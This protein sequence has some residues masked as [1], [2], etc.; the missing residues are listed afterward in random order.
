MAR[1]TYTKQ[2]WKNLPS[3]ETPVSAER[4]DYI[5]Q[6]IK[7]AMDNRALKEIYGDSSISMGRKAGTSIRTYSYAVGFNVTASAD[8]S[9]AEGYSTIAS[10]NYS[11]AEG[12][13]TK[14]S[15][16]CAHAEGDRTQA[17]SYGHAEGGMTETGGYYSHAEGY[18][19]Q[20]N[21]YCS[22]SE[23]GETQSNGRYSHAEG[24]GTLANGDHSHV[25]GMYNIADGK[26][27]Y[28]SIV[29]GGT[30]E[31]SRKN[32]Y[33]LDWSGNAYYAGDVTNGAGASLNSLKSAV[34]N[35]SD[36]AS[37]GTIAKVLDTKA[38]LDEWLAVEGNPET[39]SIG[40]N[41]YIREKDT[42]D[43]WWDGEALQVLETDKVVI[44]SMTYGE[45]MAILNESEE[46]A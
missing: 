21:G 33:T 19:T 1:D 14:A 42:P 2:E 37:R 45:A 29:G 26:S 24:R 16:Y 43:Y 35:L 22:H 39:L 3:E 44:E 36:I 46:V 15:G 11:H 34:D 20:S 40:Q 6:G 8:A 17:Y 30:S 31:T 13:E 41:I 25:H 27:E 18:Q 32:I 4:L 5:E 12:K 7:T 23:G 9:H 10:G 28:A 38:E